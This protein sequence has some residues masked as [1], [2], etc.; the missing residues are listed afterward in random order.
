MSPCPFPTT[1]TITPQALPKIRNMKKE[2]MHLFYLHKYQLSDDFVSLQCMSIYC[3]DD[4]AE[5]MRRYLAGD[6]RR[7]LYCRDLQL[8]YSHE[9]LYINIYMQ[10]HIQHN[11]DEQTHFFFRKNIP[12]TLLKGLCVR[13]SWWLNKDCNI[14]TSQLFYQP[15]FPVLLSCLTGGLGTQ[16]SAESWF[17]QFKLEHWLQTLSSNSSIG[18]PQGP[19]CWVL[20]LSTAS[21][22]Q[23]TRTSRAPS[24]IIVLRPLNLFP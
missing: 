21:Y 19:F 24:Y 11:K 7:L 10:K 8:L 16:F 4:T 3:Q 2:V 23:L 6:M 15:F 12:I 5:V 17:L 18:V 14:L 22:L 9:Q 1:I 13:G 20:V